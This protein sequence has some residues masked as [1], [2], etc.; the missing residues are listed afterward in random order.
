[1]EKSQHDKCTSGNL[2]FHFSGGAVVLFPKEEYFLIGSSHDRL[3]FWA[4]RT[5]PFITA[6]KSVLK[7]VEMLSLMA[8]ITFSSIYNILPP[9][10]AI[11]L[12]FLD[13]M[14]GFLY[15]AWTYITRSRIF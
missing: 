9:K 4:K 3:N 14:T 1:M 8:K 6:K 15:I 11:L 13:V 7:L 5:K 2:P 10:F 12:I